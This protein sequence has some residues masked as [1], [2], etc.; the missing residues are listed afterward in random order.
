MLIVFVIFIVV[1]L[2]GEVMLLYIELIIIKIRI[3]SG[4]RLCSVVSF[5]CSDVGGGVFLIR[6]GFSYVWMVM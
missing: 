3:S 1:V 5:L 2:V 6:F 4:F